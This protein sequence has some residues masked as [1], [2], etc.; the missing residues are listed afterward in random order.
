MHCVSFQ[1]TCNRHEKHQQISII[2]AH[3]DNA[4]QPFGAIPSRMQWSLPT[5]LIYDSSRRIPYLVHTRIYIAAK[6]TSTYQ[7]RQP[8]SKYS[9]LLAMI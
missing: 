8:G 2:V 6:T 4:F 1:A 9:L 5:R 7:I 3:L